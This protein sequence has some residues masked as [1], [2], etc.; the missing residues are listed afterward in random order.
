MN[1]SERKDGVLPE[2]DIRTDRFDVA[3]DAMDKASKS[4]RAKREAKIVPIDKKEDA[5][6]GQAGSAEGTGATEK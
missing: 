2:T 1:Y 6:P 5:K 4:V 3:L